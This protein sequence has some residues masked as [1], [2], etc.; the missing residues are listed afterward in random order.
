MPFHGVSR[1]WVWPSGVYTCSKCAN[2]DLRSICL[3]SSSDNSFFRT[4]SG[5]MYAQVWLHGD[6]LE[7]MSLSGLPCVIL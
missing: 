6:G 2:T 3:C 5:L 7:L 4:M 1:L